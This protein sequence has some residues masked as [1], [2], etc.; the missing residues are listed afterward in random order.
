M[1]FHLIFAL[2]VGYAD[3]TA[4]CWGHY[5]ILGGELSLGGDRDIKKK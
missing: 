4:K 1:K 5:F 3:L 2:T